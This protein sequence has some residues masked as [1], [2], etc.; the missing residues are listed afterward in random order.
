MTLN[1]LKLDS[2]FIFLEFIINLRAPLQKLVKINKSNNLK[3][4][5]F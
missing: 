1:I 4:V 3:F 5:I 2:Y